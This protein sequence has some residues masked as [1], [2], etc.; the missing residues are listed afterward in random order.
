MDK[1]YPENCIFHFLKED[2]CQGYYWSK[3]V[4][5]GEQLKRKTQ[6]GSKKFCMQA[7]H[8]PWQNPVAMPG[9]PRSQILQVKT[10]RTTGEAQ[11]TKLTL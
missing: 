6:E 10:K 1:I 9:C 3:E 11:G 7:L 4:R 5:E 8:K 2:T